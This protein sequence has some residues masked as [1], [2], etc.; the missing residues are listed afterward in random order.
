MAQALA[1][2]LLCLLALPARAAPDMAGIAFDPRPGVLL[3]LAARFRDSDGTA[4]SLGSLLRGRPL[5]VAFGYFHCPNLCGVVRDD[6]FAGLADTSLHPGVDYDVVV[7]SI[8]PAETPA[9]AQHARRGDIARYP[10]P[11]AQAGWHFLTGDSAALQAALGFRARWDAATKQFLHPAGVVAVTPAGVV[12]S[13]LLGVGCGAERLT[14]AV[15]LA[16]AARVATPPSPVLL[17]CFHYDASTGRYTLAIERV[18]RLAA[19]LTAGALGGALLLLHR[20]R[21]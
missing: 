20:A 16:A 5:L 17:L 11:G 12:S 2:L 9:Q 13:A 19:A 7:A 1:A 21:P 15:R 10:V 6:L 4:L 8:D 14:D 18:L 3:P